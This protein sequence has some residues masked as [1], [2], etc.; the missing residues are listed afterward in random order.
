VPRKKKEE[1]PAAGIREDNAGENEFAEEFAEHTAEYGNVADV[2][3]RVEAGADTDTDPDET[4]ER[5]AGTEAET[6]SDFENPASDGDVSPDSEYCRGN[7]NPDGEA[8]LPGP[9]EIRGDPDDAEELREST[10]LGPKAGDAEIPIDIAAFA[11][12]PGAGAD[13]PGRDALPA[14]A[15]EITPEAEAPSDAEEAP[16]GENAGLPLSDA[17]GH[18]PASSAKPPRQKSGRPA[19]ARRKT[20]SDLDLNALDGNLSDEERREW[21]ALYASYRAKSVLTGT[22]VGADETSFDIRNRETG[23]TERR[24]MISL[25]VIEYRVKVLI[26]ESEVWMPGEERPEHVLRNTVGGGTDYV[27]MEIDREG[28]CA[29]ASRRLALAVKRHFFAKGEHGEGELMKCRVLAVGAKQCTVE[30]NGFDIRLTQRDLSYAAIADLREKYR[31]GRELPCL[32]KAYDRK[33]GRL[34]IS[35]KEVNPNP[36][37]GADKRH[38]IGSRRQAV[39]SGKY[40]GGVFCT[41]PDDT[42]CL[43]LYSAGHADADFAA[44]DSVII[45]IRQYDYARQLIYGRILAKW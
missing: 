39:I 5:V 38:P 33:E 34:E 14:Y 29:V 28:D 7:E 22:I 23:E 41:L 30:C 27:V 18:A 16:P 10:E 43:C 9:E 8:P 11:E 2:E 26:P 42:V 3:E 35:V 44:G 32:L 37:S 19:P 4:G 45:V 1:I 36:F 6:A 13:E 24:R 21:N 31:P 40:G 20:I 12:E 17:K 25:I 15:E